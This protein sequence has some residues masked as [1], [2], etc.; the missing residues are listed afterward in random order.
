MKKIEQMEQIG[1][2]ENIRHIGQNKA[3][4]TNRTT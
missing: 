3:T 2:I 4:M 1:Q